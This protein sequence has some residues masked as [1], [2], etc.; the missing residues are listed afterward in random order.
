MKRV[1]LIFILIILFPVSSYSVEEIHIGYLPVSMSLPT[2][3]ALERGY[4][5]E[6]GLSAKAT[7][8]VSGTL[9]MDALITGLYRD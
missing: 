7:Q 1:C 5:G 9:I 4:F 8:F 3:V 6:Q 2:F